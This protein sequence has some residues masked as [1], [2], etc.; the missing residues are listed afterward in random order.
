M[1]NQQ[2][3]DYIITSKIG[4][5]EMSTIYEAKKIDDKS[6]KVV[7]KVFSDS[8]LADKE[9]VTNFST[10][11]KI[12]QNLNHKNVA[13]ILEYIQKPDLLAIIVEHIKG[14][15]LKFAVSM[16]DFTK[17]QNLSFF[18][19]ILSGIDYGHS[20]GIVHRGLDPSNIF[21]TDNYK[22]I[23]I[24]DMGMASI[25]GYD[26]PKKMKINPPMFL[27]PEQVNEEKNIDIRS[28]IYTLG[29]ILYFMMTHKSPYTRTSSYTEICEQI[30]TQEIPSITRYTIVDSIIKKATAKNPDERYQTCG[31]FLEALEKI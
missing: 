31:E 24:L 25:L 23:K 27:S 12:M 1:I 15:N 20:L 4:I 28:D 10:K 3:S 5:G 17:D 16:K 6:K 9:I 2:I 13:P 29:I 14:Q 11:A 22:N 21:F 7:I 19:Q 8:A 30:V 18:K 26:S